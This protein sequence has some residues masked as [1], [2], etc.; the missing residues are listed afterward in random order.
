MTADAGAAA[1]EPDDA[2]GG[3]TLT[4]LLALASNVGVGVLKLVAGLLTGSSAMLAE[5]AHSVADTATEGLLLT[6]LNRSSRPADRFHPFGYGKE[7]FFWALIAAV[8]VFV[9][10]A[11][12]SVYEGVASIVSGENE[13]TLAWVAYGVL[14][15]SALIEGT[16]WRQALRQV[17]S[18]SRAAGTPFMRYLRLSDDPTV[19]S[20][21]FEDSAA[22]IGLAL[23]A[24]GVGL[25]QLT[26]SGVW[27]G[28]ASL[29]IGVLL[30]LVAFILGRTNRSLLI[31]RTAGQ[32]L[33]HDAFDHIADAPE[34]DQVVDIQTMVTGT[35]SVLLCAR[36]DFV[37]TLTAADLE[38]ACVRLDDELREV[39]PD[40]DEIFIEPVP[41]N[42]PDVREA[43]LER[44]GD[45]LSR[46]QAEHD[47]RSGQGSR[48]SR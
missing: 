17:R 23:A 45:T 40:L 30:A 47:G 37:D 22:L 1:E 16:S 36:V 9:T 35:D 26:G 25:H 12:F 41:R 34:V 21:F 29:L 46:W 24:L 38:R 6:A 42:D 3:S 18:E 44:Y 15:L 19:K 43:V 13:Q 7:R 8:S 48:A 27:D 14:A 31:G 28:I 10:G 33:V 5:A 32:D 20:V 4:V 2:G 11:T 39:L